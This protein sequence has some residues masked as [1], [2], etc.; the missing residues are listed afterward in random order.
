PPGLSVYAG[1][2]ALP[3]ASLATLEGCLATVHTYWSAPDF[4]VEPWW[5]ANELEA[6]DACRKLLIESVRLRVTRSHETWG[7]LS[8][9]LDSSSVVSLTSWLAEKG[10]ISGQL[11]GTVTYVDRQGTQTDERE[12][13][14]AVVQRYGVGNVAIVDPPMWYDE[15]HQPIAPDQPGLDFHV[16][17][18]EQR[19]CEAVRGG[20]GRVLVTGYGGDELFA[21]NMFFA[22]D[23]IAEGRFVGAF[24]ELARQAA[25]G[26]AS[27]WELA[28]RNALVPLLPEIVQSHLV[29]D[30]SPPGSWLEPRA[31]R[32][33][34]RGRGPLSLRRSAGPRGLKHHHA[35]VVGVQALQ[36]V[37]HGGILSDALDL[38]HPLLYRPLVEF[39]LSLPQELRARARIPRW[40]LREAVQGIL[41][42]AVRARFGKPDTSDVLVH[43]FRA[44]YAQLLGLTEDS[45]LA[46][47]GLLDPAQL[48]AA[49]EAAHRHPTAA[50]S[51][52]LALFPT[53]AV[54]AWL[55]I[56]SGRWP[57][58]GH[59]SC[60]GRA[61][62]K[63]VIGAGKPQTQGSRREHSSS[64]NPAFSGVTTEEL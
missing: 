22:A 3:A 62:S 8:G 58:R 47:L 59:L 15:A 37:V 51:H 2:H 25:I 54:E 56:R 49:F 16:Q 7:Q 45:I 39:A 27:F 41:P 26:R 10:D 35:I 40:I 52:H 33:Y 18:R 24:Q 60:N 31:V 4:S 6:V 34:G 11:A 28:S 17:P 19:L 50:L 9:G 63:R 43:S 44:N 23:W 55:Q 1:V 38:R 46:D 32:Q 61:G 13:C 29:R 64:T 14:S 5:G 48:R 12:Y 57:H 42:E 36:G 30:E 21:S 53:L 20:G